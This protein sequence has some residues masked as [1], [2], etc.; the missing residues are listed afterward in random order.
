[1][2]LS[3]KEALV[4][5]EERVPTARYHHIILGNA[6]PPELLSVLNQL[7]RIAEAEIATL[8]QSRLC[9]CH[10]LPYLGV[11]SIGFEQRPLS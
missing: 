6:N 4:S 10:A 5:T 8:P 11:S 2:R 7:Q 3:P 9:V 1:L